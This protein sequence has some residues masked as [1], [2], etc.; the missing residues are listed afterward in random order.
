MANNSFAAI[1]VSALLCAFWWLQ[2]LSAAEGEQSREL[3]LA[4]QFVDAF[5]AFDPKLLADILSNAGKSQPDML[6]YQGWAQGGNYIVKNRLPCKTITESTVSCSITVQDDLVLALG[7]DFDVTDT[8]VL[9]LQGPN[10]VSVETSSNDPQL[11]LDARKWVWEN[12]KDLVQ[13]SCEGAD[14]VKPNPA[15]CVRDMLQGYEEYARNNGL[16]PRQPN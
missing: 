8:F 13:A 4:E 10:I 1:K 16:E 2:P 5:Y 12:R 7:I 6:F 15:Q 11:Y 3:A 9:G 14:D